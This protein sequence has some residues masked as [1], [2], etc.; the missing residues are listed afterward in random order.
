MKILYGL[1]ATGSGHI[2]RGL[3]LLPKL[4]ASGFEVDV[5]VSGDPSVSR[6]ELDDLLGVSHFFTG[7]KIWMVPGGVDYL[8]TASSQKIIQLIKDVDFI[9]NEYDLVISDY[10]P[11][12]GWWGYTHD[13]VTIGIA[14]QY[15]FWGDAPRP[16]FINPQYE[17]LYRW[18]APVHIPLGSHWPQC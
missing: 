14:H 4:R 6:E 10:E 13:V 12:A 3:A 9:P 17:F 8:K 5:I 2:S 16:A 18:V 7:L 15:A 11:V 1:Q